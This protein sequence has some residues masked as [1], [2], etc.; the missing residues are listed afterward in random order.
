MQDID[1][2]ESEKKKE[3]WMNSKWRPMMAWMYMAVCA[4]D[5]IVFPIL[6]S[7]LQSINHGQINSQWQPL[8]LQGAGLFH[9]AMGAVIGIS[10]Y[11]RTKEKMAGAENGGIGDFTSGL[12]TT[13]VPPGQGQVN[14]SNQTGMNNSM[15]GYGQ[16][17]GFNSPSSGFGSPPSGFGS[18]SSGFNSPSSGFG[19]PPSGFGSQP[20]GFN[21]PSSGFGSS[22]STFSSTST[23]SMY[24]GK[25]VP[26]AQV[27][28][29][30]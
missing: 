27:D 14:V 22:S 18:P 16:S 1:Q 5:F 4:M 29:P 15:G 11:G 30:L 2:S 13:Y 12:G 19:S 7:V 3:D 20:S 24:A 28:P 9:I 17:S 8:T 25:P 23:K 21:S 10:A 6:W 26:A